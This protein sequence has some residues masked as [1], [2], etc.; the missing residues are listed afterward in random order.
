MCRAPTQYSLTYDYTM[1]DWILMFLLTDKLISP[2]ITWTQ[3]IITVCDPLA[4]C[5][6]SSV[7][8]FITLVQDAQSFFTEVVVL[9]AKRERKQSYTS[10]KCFPTLCKLYV[11]FKIVYLF[12]G[13][14]ESYFISCMLSLSCKTSTMART[15]ASVSELF[16]ISRVFKVLLALIA[17]HKSSRQASVK[18][19]ISTLQYKRGRHI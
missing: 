17:A 12:T 13:A 19:V 4:V 9:Q 18:P 15:E 6:Q 16:L 8:Y 10:Y 3:I 11:K 14:N 5:D 1:S 7:S 2:L